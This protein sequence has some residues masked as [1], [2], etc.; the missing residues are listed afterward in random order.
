GP[1]CVDFSVFREFVPFRAADVFPGSG[2]PVGPFDAYFRAVTHHAVDGPA[3]I[4]A[5]YE[6]DPEVLDFPAAVV[7][8]AR[9]RREPVP[10]V[11]GQ[12]LRELLTAGG[13]A[14]LEI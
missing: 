4:E 3:G 2:F 8:A 9:S 7:G 13:V 1:D 10:A 12:V 11:F 6:A 14:R 5:F